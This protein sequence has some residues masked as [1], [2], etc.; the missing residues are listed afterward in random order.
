MNRC[1]NYLKELASFT[2]GRV[3]MA[4]MVWNRRSRQNR[5]AGDAVIENQTID[6]DDSSESTTRE[7]I[8]KAR[9]CRAWCRHRTMLVTPLVSER[10]AVGAIVIPHG[11]SHLRKVDRAPQML[12]L[13]KPSSLSRMFRPLR[14]PT[15]DCFRED[16]RQRPR[17][18][19]RTSQ[20]ESSANV[21][22]SR[23]AGCDHWLSEVLG[24]NCSETKTR[25]RL[26]YCERKENKPVESRLLSSKRMREK[27]QLLATR[28]KSRAT[29]LLKVNGRGWALSRAKRTSRP[30]SRWTST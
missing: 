28:S 25:N 23:A 22:R 11:G 14:E 6:V 29:R 5:V 27:P 7:Q 18:R 16:R 1:I 26:K 19:P 24:K 21:S 8:R 3:P 15:E 2:F 20:W 30:D 13:I 12:P 17:S 9:G 4:D 10:V